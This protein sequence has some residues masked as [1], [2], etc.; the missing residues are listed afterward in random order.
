MG[1]PTTLVNNETVIEKG[2]EMLALKDPIS[3]EFVREFHESV[4]HHPVPQEFLS[5]ALS[6]TLKVPARVCRDYFE[7]VL[8]TVDDTARLGEIDAPTLILWGSGTPSWD[9]RDKSAARRLSAMRRSRC[10]PIRATLWPGSGRSGSCGTW[11]RS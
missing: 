8:L 11:R 5:T 4:I 10:T 2:E 7:G 3:P 6:E 1:S 9:A